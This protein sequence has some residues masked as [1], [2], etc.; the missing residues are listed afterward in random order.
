ML[1]ITPCLM[2]TQILTLAQGF[3]TAAQDSNLGSRSRESEALPLSHCALHA[4]HKGNVTYNLMLHG[5]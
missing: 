5:K 2:L 1:M 3:N 4:E